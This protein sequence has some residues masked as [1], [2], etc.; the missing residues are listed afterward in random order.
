MNKQALFVV[1]IVA[2]T[3]GALVISCGEDNAPHEATAS[4]A[5]STVAETSSSAVSTSG[6][7]GSSSVSTGGGGGMGGAG[8]A[9]DC[10]TNPKTH[11]EIINACTDADKQD[12]KVSLPLEAADGGLPPLP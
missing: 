3:V 11:V 12:K 6:S 5:V 2:S 9:G 7:G 8:G 1:A 4:S 10:Y